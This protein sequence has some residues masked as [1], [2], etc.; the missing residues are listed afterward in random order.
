M[1]E[2]H[3]ENPL[4]NGSMKIFS[5]CSARPN[6]VKL[7]AV[8]HA[9]EAKHWPGEH[10]ILHT[11]QHHDAVFSDVFFQELHIPLPKFNLGIHGGTND[12]QQRRVEEA[13]GNIF[14]QERPDLVLVYGDVNGAAAAARAA[15]DIGIQVGHVEAGLRSGDLSMPEERN[16]IVIDAIS[17]LLFVSEQSG[18]EHLKQ[19]HVAGK[20][21]FVGNTMIDTLIRML[22]AIRAQPLPSNLPARFAVAT[23]HRPSNVD[24]R[25]SLKQ[26]VS[27]LNALSS[28]IPVVFPIHRR[29]RDR[30]RDWGLKSDFS[31]HILALD[32][33]PYLSFLRLIIDAH[34][35]LTDSGGIQEE[36]TYLRR[37][38]FTARP[39]TERPVTIELGTNELVGLNDVSHRDRIFSFSVENE[40]P[41]GT[42]P[43]L[44]D[45]KAGERIVDCLSSF[46][47]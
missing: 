26:I 24:E 16:R 14:V 9:L 47:R 31:R 21:F 27:F 15:A 20:A 44:W 23:F 40:E 1:G 17:S 4:R 18:M 5:I 28:R 11:G 38:C 43:P 35:V 39:N 19:E 37:K 10:F 36:T 6:F 30:L 42:I 46:S 33:L 29:T 22:P 45:G 13:C 25:D 2:A 12:E 34:F 7:A 32:P 41:R 3:D 8:H